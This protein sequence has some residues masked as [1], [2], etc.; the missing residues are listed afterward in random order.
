[1]RALLDIGSTADFSGDTYVPVVIT[2]TAGIGQA[3]KTLIYVREHTKPTKKQ[4]WPYVAISTRCAHLGCP[5]R[6]IEAARSFICPCHGGTYN[7]EGEVTAGPPV[8]PLD[9]F[10]T[11]VK[12]GRVLVGER[13]SVNSQLERVATRDPGNH[14]DGLWQILYPPRPTT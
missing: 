10:E 6:F 1:H 8:R 13:F 12:D 2:T 14:V 7:Y 11:F 4:P 3:G 9:R 5:V